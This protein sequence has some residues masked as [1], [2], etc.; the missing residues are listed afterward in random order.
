MSLEPRM[1]IVN[2]AETHTI[3]VD[4]IP[5]GG[6]CYYRSGVIAIRVGYNGNMREEVTSDGKKAHPFF[7]PALAAITLIPRK[8]W[9]TVA[10]VFIGVRESGGIID[11]TNEE[12]QIDETLEDMPV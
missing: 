8:K 6:A 12:P 1:E 4:N 7:V 9:V 10:N 11:A 2:Y 3:L 5:P